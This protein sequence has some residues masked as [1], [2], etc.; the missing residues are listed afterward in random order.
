MPG[1]EDPLEHRHDEEAL[2]ANEKAAMAELQSL[3][4][5][6]LGG[7][8]LRDETPGVERTEPEVP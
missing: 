6:E 4:Q 7:R 5:K 3:F 2:V 8:P 1:D